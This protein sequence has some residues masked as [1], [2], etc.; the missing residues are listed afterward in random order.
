MFITRVHMSCH[1][2]NGM[3]GRLP[4]GDQAAIA[5]KRPAA[6][7]DDDVRAEKFN[8][9]G[10]YIMSRKSELF[11]RAMTAPNCLKHPGELCPVAW[12][13]GDDVPRWKRP[14]TTHAAGSS[15]KPFTSQGTRKTSSHADTEAW[16]LY[17]NDIAEQN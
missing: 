11:G 15:C 10:N 8:E 2:F 14:L 16:N 6:L 3:L 13:C 9:M 5:G 4:L 7:D 1:V 12:Q 17:I